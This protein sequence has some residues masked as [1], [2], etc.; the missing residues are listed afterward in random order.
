MN[1][2]KWEL[3]FDKYNLLDDNDS[4]MLDLSTPDFI[5]LVKDLVDLR[6]DVTGDSSTSL[7]EAG[8]IAKRLISLPYWDKYK[9][10]AKKIQK[11]A[12]EHFIEVSMKSHQVINELNFTLRFVIYRLI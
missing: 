2:V 7:E 4:D 10:G 1:K 6:D 8:A 3:L 5:F 11:V 12:A 9:K